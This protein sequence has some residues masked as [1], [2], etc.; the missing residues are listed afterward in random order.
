MPLG[1]LLPLACDTA[2]AE[3]RHGACC[4]PLLAGRQA[5]DYV[6][7]LLATRAQLGAAGLELEDSFW[8]HEVFVRWWLAH[9]AGHSHSS[10]TV[11]SS[12]SAA[13]DGVLVR[14]LRRLVYRERM[15]LIPRRRLPVAPSE[16]AA[17]AAAAAAPPAAAGAAAAVPPASAEGGQGLHVGAFVRL[18]GL[19]HAAGLWGPAT[20]DLFRVE[21]ALLHEGAVHVVLRWYATPIDVVGI[22]ACELARTTCFRMILLSDLVGLAYH[23]TATEQRQSASASPLLAGQR[24]AVDYVADLLATRKQLMDGGV[25]FQKAFWAAETFVQWWLAN[26][27]GNSYTSTISS[28]AADGDG[29]GNGVLARALRSPAYRERRQQ[30]PRRRCSGSGGQ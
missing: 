11:V 10:A 9:P 16:A 28:C 12:C 4:S 15:R 24:A 6:A 5:V 22:G 1:E 30:I 23:T 17:A 25:K 8:Q 3:Q 27:A 2:T 19:S 7:D 21:G 13:A 14:D 20:V 26:P 29:G 18:Q